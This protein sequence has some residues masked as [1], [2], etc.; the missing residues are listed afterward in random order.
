MIQFSVIIPLY[1]KANYIRETLNSV[2]EQTYKHFQVIIVDDGST[3]NSFEIVSEIHDK[4]ISIYRKQNEGVSIARNYGIHKANNK[5][6]AFLDADDIW[7]PDY[8]ETINGLIS[9]YPQV[10]IYSTAYK[11]IYPHKEEDLLYYNEKKKTNKEFII[12]D[13]YKSLMN[14]EMFPLW[15]GAICVK[16]ELFNKVGFFPEKIKRGEDLDMWLRLCLVSA[17]AIYN[18]SKV[19]YNK[20]TE[21]NAMSSYNSYKESFPYWEWYNYTQSKYICEYTTKSIKGLILTAIK[22]KK[23]RDAIFLLKKIK[24]SKRINTFIFII[25][26]YPRI[27]IQQIK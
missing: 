11:I 27:L 17:I 21:N 18:V 19:L 6:I 5:Y 1:N 12:E 20:K 26:K 15:T 14:N 22:F 9:K 7:L 10:G 24:K 13:Y 23:F 3:D 4:R 8:L 2:L 16:K 25:K